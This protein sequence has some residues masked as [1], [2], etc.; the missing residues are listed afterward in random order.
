MEC[1]AFML[2]FD[3]LNKVLTVESKVLEKT[4]Y[5]EEIKIYCIKQI[6]AIRELLW[7]S[8]CL[9]DYD[10]QE[11]LKVSINDF[12]SFAVNKGLLKGEKKYLTEKLKACIQ[13]CS[14]VD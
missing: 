5:T 3:A 11:S 12:Y 10:A 8:E 4:K 6:K 13:L 2:D 7:V 1:D 14:I 9:M